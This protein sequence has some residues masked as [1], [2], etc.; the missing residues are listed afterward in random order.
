MAVR[1]IAPASNPSE[2]NSRVMRSVQDFEQ[3]RFFSHWARL[4]PLPQLDWT[5]V[6]TGWRAVGISG[7]EVRDCSQRCPFFNPDIRGG[8]AHVPAVLLGVNPGAVYMKLPV[9]LG[10]AVCVLRPLPCRN[11]DHIEPRRGI[12]APPVNRS[13]HH[14]WCKV[15]SH[16]ER[17]LWS[18][19]CCSRGNLHTQQESSD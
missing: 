9:V 11:V 7:E 10:A 8:N 15:S 2:L 1:R 6:E 14:S 17:N 13:W 3:L 12:S 16:H 19:P 18:R 4:R 5:L